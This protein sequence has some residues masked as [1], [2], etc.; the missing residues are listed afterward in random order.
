MIVKVRFHKSIQKYTD[1]KEVEFNIAT[2]RQLESALETAFP[3]LKRIMKQVKN[4]SIDDGFG[5]YDLDNKRLLTRL[6]Y[7]QKKIKSNMLYLMP[8]VAG[9]KRAG[10]TQMILGAITFA[11]G[12][13]IF[14]YV[15]GGQEFG[16]QMMITGATMFI[17]GVVTYM[18]TPPPKDQESDAAVRD[19]NAFG[20][21]RNTVET[22]TSIPLVYGRHRVAGHFISGEVRTLEKAPTRLDG[23][24]LEDL[25]RA[26]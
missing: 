1:M 21:L 26:V 13:A 2:Y 24:T 5:L 20:S 25:V 7:L 4:R 6:D 22:G 16:T 10:V 11:I 19:N 9:H 15:P 23:E 17:G 8:F 12:A 14:A 3:K 18:L